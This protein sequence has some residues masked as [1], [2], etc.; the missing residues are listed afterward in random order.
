[1]SKKST[2]TSLNDHNI[3]LMLGQINDILAFFQFLSVL[4]LMDSIFNYQI[5]KFY[6]LN[7]KYIGG[8]FLLLRSDVNE[9]LLIFSRIFSESSA[10]VYLRFTH[11]PNLFTR[12]LNEIAFT[13]VLINQHC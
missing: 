8:K 10:A 7:C 9:F 1:M 3:C 2:C 13:H 4:R 5:E 6:F 11:C 12:P